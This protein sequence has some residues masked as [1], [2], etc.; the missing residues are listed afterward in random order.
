MSA[1][2]LGGAGIIAGTTTIGT[3]AF[4]RPATGAKTP[5]TLTIQNSLIFASDS[6]YTCTFKAKKAKSQNDKVVANGVTLNSGAEF[7]LSGQA[8]GQLRQGTSFTVISNTASTP[9]SGTFADHADGAIITVGS[10]KFQANY[11]GGDGND[12]TLT[13]VP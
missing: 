2:T 5:V 7:S 13:V 1:G 10:T 3:G 6:T 12:L 11:E 8:W 9:I 4:L